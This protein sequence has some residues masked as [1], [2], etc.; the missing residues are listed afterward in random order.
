[1]KTAQKL[2][3]EYAQTPSGSFARNYFKYLGFRRDLT[4]PPATANANAIEALFTLPEPYIY[5]ND[6]I[7]GSI[8]PL[9]S[10]V[11]RTELDYANR[12]VV[13]FGVRGFLHNVDHFAPNYR[14]TTKLG[15]MGLVGEIDKSCANHTEPDRLEYL[16]AMKQT[17]LAQRTMILRYAEKA[18]S[19]RGEDGYI[20]ERLDEIAAR[21]RR[22][23]NGAPES[24]ADAL[25]LVWFCHLAFVMEGRYA[26][27]LGRIDQYL[28]PF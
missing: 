4:A 28:W 24:F 15:I 10:E 27:A 8:R 26:M 11:D 22:I 25:Q 16:S 3:C 20:P 9:W 23:A 13:S 12:I 19:L 1:M 2:K 18:E 14:K 5:K 6:L 17:L 7:V 21:C